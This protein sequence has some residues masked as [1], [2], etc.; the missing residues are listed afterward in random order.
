MRGKSKTDNDR[1]QRYSA[2][3]KNCKTASECLLKSC[4]YFEMAGTQTAQNEPPADPMDVDKTD[5]EEAHEAHERT[6]ES[7]K[8]GTAV[9]ATVESLV[10][11]RENEMQALIVELRSNLLHA[12]WLAEQCGRATNPELHGTHY[13]QWK[14][15]MKRTGLKDPEATSELHRYLHEALENVDADTEELY[16]RDPPTPE[17]LEREKKAADK[18]KKKAKAKRTAERKAK[19]AEEKNQ[20]RE[21]SKKS[22]ARTR[23]PK[24]RNAPESDH[25]EEGHSDGESGNTDDEIDPDAPDP[26]PDKVGKDD[27][28]TYASILRKLTGHLRNL[29]T[30]LT[31]RTRSLR[32]ARGAQELYEWSIDHTKPPQCRTCTNVIIP[33]DFDK[34]VDNIFVSIRC[35][36]ITCKE[37]IENKGHAKCA[38]DGCGEGSESFRLRKVADLVGD[39]TAW[40]HG[41][42]LGNII[43]LINGLPKDDQVLLFVQFEDVMLSMAAQLKA[44][45]ISNYALRG[46]R[47]MVD[48]MNDFQENEREDKK[49]VLLLNSANATAAGM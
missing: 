23:T 5:N 4:S 39:G 15:E 17:E 25:A 22:S 44:A 35:G 38:V 36:H 47:E 24:A 37:C 13:H 34:G 41:S 32:F 28:A 27:F 18:R 8:P 7:S 48:M 21:L 43:T 9:S 10:T 12:A 14:S 6:Y 46:G 31:S 19:K 49:K 29:V 40:T 20:G 26:K 30:E 2:L 33:D 3:L 1:A 16:Y 11:R 42:R 45:N